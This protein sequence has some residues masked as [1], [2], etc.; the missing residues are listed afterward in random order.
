[1]GKK[2]STNAQAFHHKSVSQ[3]TFTLIK[4]NRN[5]GDGSECEEKAKSIRDK[6]AIKRADGDERSELHHRDKVVLLFV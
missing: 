6:D 4:N 1:M 5:S 2:K 3:P